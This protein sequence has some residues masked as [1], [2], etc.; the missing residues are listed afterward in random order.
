MS[1]SGL[2]TF[3]PEVAEHMDE[4]WERIGK[5]PSKLTAKH[6]VAMR[7]SMNYMMADWATRG[8]LLW[9]MR[10]TS[11][12]T[13]QGVGSITLDEHL[14]ALFDATLR[15][16]GSDV[17]MV[18]MARD[19]YAAIV[20]KDQQGRP[21]QYF[22]ERTIPPVLRLWQ[23]PENSSDEVR[24][25]G[26]FRTESVTDLY[27]EPEIPYRYQEAFAAGLAARLAE[28]YA[29]AREADLFAKAEGALDRASD[30]DRERT[31]TQLT[32]GRRR[33]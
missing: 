5:D 22:L 1:T 32:L 8:I 11:F 31:D 6:I 20:N 30:A 4:A 29:K 13:V 3:N 9:T 33:R 16:E 15:R 14:I 19:E 7:R 27:Q 17:P 23:L 2:Y 26:F 18:P 28:K 21:D 25:W 12:V 10:E 24:Y